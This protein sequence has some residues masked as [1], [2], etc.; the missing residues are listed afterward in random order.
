MDLSEIQDIVPCHPDIFKYIIILGASLLGE[1]D[2][3]NAIN[4]LYT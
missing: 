4:I 2:V 1:L 3:F